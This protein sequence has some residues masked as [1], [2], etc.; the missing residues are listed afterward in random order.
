MGILNIG[1]NPLLGESYAH[2]FVEIILG[3]P[4]TSA[5]TVI[6]Q[7][8]GEPMGGSIW[9][10]AGSYFGDS[11]GINVERRTP[12]GETVQRISSHT[13]ASGV[14]DQVLS[15]LLNEVQDAALRKFQN[16]QYEIPTLHEAVPTGLPA[17]T[18]S[19]G[20]LTIVII[21]NTFFLPGTN[22][23][24]RYWDIQNSNTVAR[25]I[26]TEMLNRLQQLGYDVGDLPSEPDLGKGV[27][28]PGWYND[29]SDLRMTKCFPAHTRIQTSR[30]TSTAIS[31]LRVGD[32]VLAFDARADKGRGALV[33]RR[34][35]RLYRN[36][37]TDW[38]RLRWQGGT[39]EVITTPGHHFLDAFGGFPTTLE[40]A[41]DGRARVGLASGALGEV[42]A[43]RVALGAGK[44]P[45]GGRAMGCCVG[46]G[47]VTVG[48]RDGGAS[49]AVDG[50]GV[51]GYG[52]GGV[53]GRG[54]RGRAGG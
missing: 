23:D 34:V 5:P 35:T 7:V 33:P 17:L 14:P 32:V 46:D 29:A 54:R 1:A 2:A 8:H 40:M 43:G 44:A 3:G 27:D 24:Q 47:A 42:T 38:L 10:G 53:M 15:N 41:K 49:G 52:A 51:R 36:T 39:R 28:L 16:A 4:H 48:E 6:R 12:H 19:G 20:G 30:T 37:T 13:L 25:W 9:G 31:A 45:V 18:A 11:T 21:P 22:P 50:E 26:A